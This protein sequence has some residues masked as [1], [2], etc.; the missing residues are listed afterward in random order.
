VN[1]KLHILGHPDFPL[2]VP[3]H[4][5]DSQLFN[6]WNFCQV[7]EALG[8]PYLYYGVDGSKCPPGNCGSVVELGLSPERWAFRSAWHFDYTKRLNDALRAHLRDNGEPEWVASIYGVA[9]CD[10]EVPKGIPVFEP[11]LGYGTC[12]T[13]YRVFPSYAQ[14]QVIYT[15]Q[16]ETRKDRYFD[17]VIPHFINPADYPMAE[18][19]GDYLVYLGR[20][21]EDKGI[22]L[23]RET[24][25]TA[26]LEF[27]EVHRGCAGEE[28]AKL[29]G[30]AR[31]VL[32]PTLYLEPFG[33]VAIEA[34]MCG[35]PVITTDWGAFPEI[36]REGVDGFRCRT[37]A[38]FADA[39]KLAP[40]LD[41]QR[42]RAGALERY[43]VQVVAPA[44]GRYFDFIWNAHRYGG[45]YA[46]DTSRKHKN[47]EHHS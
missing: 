18:K 6:C 8:I 29:L 1:C 9:Q 26:G 42:I 36:I 41:R 22:T 3:G 20:A 24:A 38:E 7:A 27:R 35:T 5:E 39:V 30:E 33:Y 14:Q 46:P 15:R 13:H 10:V 25:A 17:T 28:K 32:M 23:A 16:A 37:A 11:M 47:A 12:W 19:P 43:T 4:S 2:G 40:S 34:M 44:Y 21:A 31:A 45:Y